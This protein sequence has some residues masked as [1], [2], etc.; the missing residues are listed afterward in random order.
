MTY[1]QY[2][3]TQSPTKRVFMTYTAAVSAGY[4][5]CYDFDNVNTYQNESTSAIALTTAAE[6]RRLCVE[7]PSVFNN[8]HFAGAIAKDYAANTMGQWIEIYPPGSICNI[9]LCSVIEA[10]ME[11]TGTGFN[12]GELLTF[13][14]DQWF[15]HKAGF[16]GKGSAEILQI[17]SGPNLCMAELQ[18]GPQSGGYQTLSVYSGT[19][20]DYSILISANALTRGGVTEIA[21]VHYGTDTTA[22]CATTCEYILTGGDFIGQRKLVL[23]TASAVCK[24]HE[25]LINV[26]AGTQVA[27]S[28][29]HSAGHGKTADPSMS[30]GESVLTFSSDKTTNEGMTKAMFTWEGDA[31]VIQAN[32]DFMT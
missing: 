11:V 21:S 4:P 7:K 5:V 15:F 2:G 30:I 19:T 28:T 31:W 27:T 29:V 10:H 8:N 23:L 3:A 9:R 16:P 26:T 1:V 22:I 18:T 20:A 13:E 25:I 6:S 24:A 14:V 32:V 17:A 12:T